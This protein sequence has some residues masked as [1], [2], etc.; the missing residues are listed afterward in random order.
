MASDFSNQEMLDRMRRIAEEAIARGAALA[1]AMPESSARKLNDALA[2]ALRI[3]QRTPAEL[4]RDYHHNLLRSHLYMLQNWRLTIEERPIEPFGVPGL[5]VTARGVPGAARIVAYGA[6]PGGRRVYD[7]VPLTGDPRDAGYELLIAKQ[8]PALWASGPEVHLRTA[9][10]AEV[11]RAVGAWCDAVPLPVLEV[12]PIGANDLKPLR[13]LAATRAAIAKAAEAGAAWS[14]LG[15]LVICD[16]AAPVVPSPEGAPF[17]EP[18]TLTPDGAAALAEDLAAIDGPRLLTNVPRDARGQLALGVD[19]AL[20]SYASSYDDPTIPSRRS[21]AWLVA[22]TPERRRDPQVVTLTLDLCVG[23]DRR[24][25]WNETRWL[26]DGRVVADE[27]TRWGVTGLDPAG[28]RLEGRAGRIAALRERLASAGEAVQEADRAAL[29]ILLQDEGHV[30]EALDLYGI[31]LDERLLAILRGDPE[32]TLPADYATHWPP[33][34]WAA[35]R[36][37]APWRCEGVLRAE[38]ARVVARPATKSARKRKPVRLRL[39]S[40]PKQ[41][42]ISKASVMLVRAEDGR[43]QLELE[44]T[45][46]TSIV[47]E[48]AWQRPVELDLRRFGR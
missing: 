13:A 36:A 17:P 43:P 12:Q 22:R 24:H 21:R 2:N 19:V 9:D 40:L 7:A 35:L 8:A 37:L 25:R 31:T 20:A 14:A 11:A 47:P 45:G 32:G 33:A 34:L 48:V 10:P 38:E 15:L 44:S 23:G 46:T 42:A 3:M 4:A 16:P 41:T 30:Q 6:E 1:E 18:V 28:L 27:T 5:I 26:W 29:C 39:L